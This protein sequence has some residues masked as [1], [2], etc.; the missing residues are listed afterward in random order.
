MHLRMWAKLAS[1]LQTAC[2]T[3][4][5]IFRCDPASDDAWPQTHLRDEL[6]ALAR[7][8]PSETITPT[9][10]HSLGAEGGGL[11]TKRSHRSGL[12]RRS[13]QRPR[14]RRNLERAQRQGGQVGRFGAG[15]AARMQIC[16][17][18]SRT[19]LTCSAAAALAGS[20]PWMANA[21]PE[22]IQKSVHGSGSGRV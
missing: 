21:R 5:C 13:R 3:R 12:A 6:V 4:C 10:S 14:S 11:L 19:P 8:K 2:A 1:L 22:A 7:M 20:R 9:S 15:I 17:A 18:S 16:R